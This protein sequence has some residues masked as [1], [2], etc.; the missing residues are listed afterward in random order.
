MKKKLKPT[1]S[2][3]AKGYTVSLG[4]AL[5]NPHS[6]HNTE[7][8]GITQTTGFYVQGDSVNINYF[9]DDGK[10]VLRRYYL[11]GSTRIYQDSAAGT[12]DYSTGLITIN[13]I[14]LTST[15]N[16]DTS[17]DFTVIPSGL[18]VV[19]ERGNLIDISVDD[20]KTT[21]EVDT[22]ASGESSAGV[23]FNTTSTSSY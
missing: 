23:G 6:G 10:G 14:T 4:N 17:I 22:I 8:G 18:D 2:S 9:D 16:T 15:V 20:I 19:A 11:S 7:S 21:G 3:N 13:A 5:Y 1:I 12:V